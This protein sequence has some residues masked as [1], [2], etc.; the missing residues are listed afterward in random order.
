MKPNMI[1]LFLIL[2]IA[3]GCFAQQQSNVFEIITN[4][5]SNKAISVYYKDK[6]S[7]KYKQLPKFK[8]PTSDLSTIVTKFPTKEELSIIEND[9]FSEKELEKSGRVLIICDIHIPT[10]KIVSASFLTRDTN[11]SQEKIELYNKRIKKELKFEIILRS[12]LVKEGYARMTLRA[13]QK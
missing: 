7:D 13:M 6:E 3:T 5:D 1:I 4:K 2:Q 12:E 9:I 10:G 8:T 11:I